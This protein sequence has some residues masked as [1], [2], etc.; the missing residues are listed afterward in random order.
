MCRIRLVLYA[1]RSNPD[2]L[3]LGLLILLIVERACHYYKTKNS[4]AIYEE[5]PEMQEFFYF[6]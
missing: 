3:G 6:F 4:S 5:N 1:H 2:L